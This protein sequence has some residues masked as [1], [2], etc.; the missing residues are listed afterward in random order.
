MTRSVELE[1]KALPDGLEMV[2]GEENRDHPEHLETQEFQACPDLQDP[3][4]ISSLSLIKS[5]PHRAAKKDHHQ[6]HSLTCKLKLDRWDLEDLLEIGDLPDP[7]VSWDHK[8]TQVIPDNQGRLEQWGQEVFQVL[9]EKK[10]NLARMENQDR[11]DPMDHLESV[12]YLECLEYQVR[13]D[14]VAFLDWM[15]LK[16]KLEGLEKRERKELLVL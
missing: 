10:V 13:R 14:I 16:E 15:E 6:I 2:D 11:P 12:D 5:R 4:Q 7:R 9:W 1:T 8:E 3:S